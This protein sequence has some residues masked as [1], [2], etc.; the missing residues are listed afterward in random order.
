MEQ[1]S[2]AVRADPG[3]AAPRPISSRYR[4]STSSRRIRAVPA[5]AMTVA[6]A[7]VPHASASRFEAPRASASAVAP[8]NASPAPTE[9]CIGTSIAGIRSTPSADA[10]SAP[11]RP[12]VSATSRVAPLPHQRHRLGI[13]RRRLRQVPPHQQ[14]QLVERRLHQFQPAP[15][16]RRPQR[17]ARGVQRKPLPLAPRRCAPYQRRYRPARR[18]AGCR[19]R[20]PTR[21]PSL[22]PRPGTP[23]TPPASASAPPARS[24]IPARYAYPARSG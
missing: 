13:L 19:W 1:S 5:Q 22:P 10:S 12:S 18:A 4:R 21:P 11:S 2:L 24:G 23:G 6:P 8:M 15:L 3:P 17:H 7:A 16:Q 14:L 9:L 20:S